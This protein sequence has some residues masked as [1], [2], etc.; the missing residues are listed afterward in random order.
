MSCPP[1]PPFSPL[2]LGRAAQAPC[3]LRRG[4]IAGIN[5]LPITDADRRLRRP[6]GWCPFAHPGPTELGL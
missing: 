6:A 2:V 3:A 4:R 5:D 1:Y